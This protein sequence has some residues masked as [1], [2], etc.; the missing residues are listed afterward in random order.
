MQT[1]TERSD[2][3]QPTRKKSGSYERENSSISGGNINGECCSKGKETMR[4]A[5]GITKHTLDSQE[6]NTCKISEN[7]EKQRNSTSSEGASSPTEPKPVLKKTIG[8][9]GN[10]VRKQVTIEDK[11]TVVVVKSD[12]EEEKP[13]DKLQKDS[14]SDSLKYELLLANNETT[15]EAANDDDKLEDIK[16]EAPDLTSADANEKENSNKKD[17]VSKKEENEPKKD[18]DNEDKKEEN[19]EK[20]DSVSDKEDET[21]EKAVNTSPGGRLLK[22]DTEIGRGSFKTVRH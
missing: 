14:S 21:E 10:K 1:D 2:D 15:K 6:E 17:Q 8:S 16:I 4:K 7:L 5:D 3:V 22:F 9:S 11:A 18:E 19:G 20:K 13:K 12:S